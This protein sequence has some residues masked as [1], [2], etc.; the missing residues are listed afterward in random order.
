MGK[1]TQ[2]VFLIIGGTKEN[3]LNEKEKNKEVNTRHGQ[4]PNDVCVCVSERERE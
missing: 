4:K 3:G 2:L 1:K